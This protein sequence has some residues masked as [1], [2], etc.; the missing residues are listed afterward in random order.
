MSIKRSVWAVPVTAVILFGL[1]LAMMVYFNLTAITTGTTY[2]VLTR[3]SALVR[4]IDTLSDGLAEAGG[5]GRSLAALATQA[6][7]VR[8][9]L[10]AL[11]VLPEQAA[12][13]ERL[14]HEFEAWYRPAMQAR[15]MHAQEGDP[16]AL[17]EVIERH[18]AVLQADLAEARLLALRS[19]ADSAQEDNSRAKRLLGLTVAGAALLIALLGLAAW[20]TMRADERQ[21][22]TATPAGSGA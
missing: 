9:H 16:G 14:T 22:R 17:F 7:Q 18:Y 4:E 20:V 2:P 10:R 6:Q 21:S 1:V 15:L 5:E 8:V 19:F 3:I 11:S 12:F 13:A